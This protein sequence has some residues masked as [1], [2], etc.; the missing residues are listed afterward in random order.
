VRGRPLLLQRRSRLIACGGLLWALA[1]PA[2]AGSATGQFPVQITLAN[3]LFA[4][5]PAGTAGGPAIGSFCINQAMSQATQATVTVVCSTNQFVSIQPIPGSA[6]VGVPNGGAYR[7][8]LKPDMLA[9]PN[10]Q[11][12]PAGTGT[13]TTMEVSRVKHGK[14]EIEEIQINY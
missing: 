2:L 10:E 13:V 8:L 1:A 4:G 5:T 9:A 11:S 14:W 6:F 3:P 7:F 12:W